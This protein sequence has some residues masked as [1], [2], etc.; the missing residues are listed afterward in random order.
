MDTDLLIIGGGPAGLHA[1]N[2]VGQY[3]IRTVIVEESNALGGL[4]R[5]QVHYINDLPREFKAQTGQNL[6]EYF[7]GNLSDQC[8]VLLNHIFTGVYKDG[9]LGI[10]NQET[11]IPIRA[12]RVLIATG[13]AEETMI[14]PGW[15]LPG[16]ISV[17]AGQILH[18]R[19]GVLPGKKA[20]ILG[21]SEPALSLSMDLF[22]KG[23]DVAIV[24]GGS[25]ISCGNQQLLDEI[26][27]KNI[28][29]YFEAFNLEALGTDEVE[30]LVFQ[31]S[32]GNE[33]KLETDVVC[34]GGEY[35]PI[36]ESF[37]I[38]DC[39]FTYAEKLG[40]WLPQYDH[41]LKT[42]VNHVFAAG[43]C[44]GITS[45]SGILLTAEIAS[46]NVVHELMNEQI[47]EQVESLWEELINIE[48]SSFL[49]S[50]HSRKDIIAEAYT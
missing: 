41:T 48:D 11:V 27:T 35:S 28:P 9:R 43:N 7:I 8:T 26:V 6:S 12:K 1:A 36:L 21:S 17:G 15:T 29:I 16:V 14:F 40:G 47:Q 39:K 2:T 25:E 44:A 18:H 45:M 23:S 3:G 33:K 24:D 5:Q 37:E 50:F 22:D 34:I 13:A 20:V 32:S 31:Q 19:E 30:K 4:L 38:L 49:P 42:S 46:L 10:A